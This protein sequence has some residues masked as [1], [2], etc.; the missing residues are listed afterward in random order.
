[1]K[2]RRTGVDMTTSAHCPSPVAA[3]AG[4]NHSIIHAAAS[5]SGS[6]MVPTSMDA[7]RAASKRSEHSERSCGH[8]DSN[9]PDRAEAHRYHALLACANAAAKVASVHK[10]GLAFHKAKFGNFHWLAEDFDPSNLE[11]SPDEDMLACCSLDSLDESPVQDCREIQ[12]RD[13]REL[14]S[15]VAASIIADTIDEAVPMHPL[16]TTHVEVNA[17][18]LQEQIRDGGLSCELSSCLQLAVGDSEEGA[19]DAARLARLLALEAVRVLANADFELS[20][21]ELETVR[22]LCEGLNMGGVLEL[23]EHSE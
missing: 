19:P 1:M 2:L 17:E 6:G 22:E 18:L 10:A 20:E 15:S 13:V 4:R 11:I 16:P 7:G 21:G 23:V 12:R 9:D 8:K 14:A 5:L 3:R